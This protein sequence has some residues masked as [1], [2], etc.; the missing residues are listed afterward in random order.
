MMT[1]HRSDC[2]EDTKALLDKVEEARKELRLAEDAAFDS[3]SFTE[4]DP[5]GCGWEPGQS[6]DLKYQWEWPDGFH[7]LNRPHVSRLG[8]T[9]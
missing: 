3:A 5:H 6:K 2:E 8:F 1:L 4:H 7:S 9:A